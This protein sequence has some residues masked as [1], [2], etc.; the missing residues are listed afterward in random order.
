MIADRPI[1][2]PADDKGRFVAIG[3]EQWKHQMTGGDSSIMPRRGQRDRECS[4]T[5]LYRVPGQ[6]AP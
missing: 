6:V 4:M 1:R 3:E 5:R 2:Y